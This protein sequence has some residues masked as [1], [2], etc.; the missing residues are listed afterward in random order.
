MTKKRRA[1]KQ[2]EGVMPKTPRL[3]KDDFDNIERD[4]K[5]QDLEKLWHHIN[6]KQ[7]IGHSVQCAVCGES[8]WQKCMLCNV[9]LHDIDSKGKHAKKKCFT[10]WHDNTM[11][12]LCYSDAKDK[13]K[14]TPSSDVERRRNEELIHRLSTGS[15]NTR[16][17]C[18]NPS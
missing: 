9:G 6:S 7:A 12:G 16:L 10:E 14:W 17:T 3:L 1:K 2:K 15:V 11:V 5:K 8:V 18:Q 13:K 4:Q